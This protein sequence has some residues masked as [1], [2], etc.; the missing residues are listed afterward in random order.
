MKSGV[1]PVRRP[2]GDHQQPDQDGLRRTAR[3]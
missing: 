2:P 3:L 1:H